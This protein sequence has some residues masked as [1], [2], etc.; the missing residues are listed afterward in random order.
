MKIKQCNRNPYFM[1]DLAYDGEFSDGGHFELRIPEKDV[2]EFATKL[3]QA[4]KDDKDRKVK[5]IPPHVHILKKVIFFTMG[6]LL[7]TNNMKISQVIKKLQEIQ[8]EKG[9]VEVLAVFDT[10]GEGEWVSLE[11]DGISF[12]RFNEGKN[13]VYIGW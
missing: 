3:L 6:V 12:D 1:A 11:E 5:V 7:K 2:E 8:K 10:Y 13:I 9:D 4:Y